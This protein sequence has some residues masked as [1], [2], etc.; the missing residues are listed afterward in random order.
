MSKKSPDVQDSEKKSPEPQPPKKKRYI[1]KKA[2]NVTGDL[3][4]GSI[5]AVLKVIGTI[6]LIFLVAGMMF[7]CVFAYYVKT[8]L[9]PSFDLSLEDLKLN[10]SSTLW[11]QDASGEWRE[12][13]TLSGSEKRVWV[14][15]ED[16]PWYLEKAL[17]AIEDKRFYEHKGVDWYRTAGAF[18]TM[19][20]KMDTSYGGSTITQQL[21]KNLTGKDDVTIQRKLSEI[22]GALELE[23]RYD[24]QEIVEW[25]LNA[26]CFGQGCY[27]VQ[28]AAQTYFGK[29]AKDLTLAESAAIVGI[30][31]LPTYY[32]PF[33]NEQNNK[34]R[35]E[36]ILREMYEQGYIDYQQYKDAVAEELVFT[37]SPGEEYSQ[38]IYS[39]YTEVV[40]DD[41]INDLMQLKGISRETA[42]TL[43]RNGG[44]NV[45][46]CLDVNVQNNI[47][48][49]YT[50]LE[51]IPNTWG[52]D[53]QLQSAIVV[54]DPYDG[55]ILGLSGGVGEKTINFGLNR[56]TGTKR[57]PGS[58]IK[59]LSAYGPAI[60]L[61]LITPE[62]TV[63]DSPNVV[64][65]GIDWLP[66]N[67]SRSYMGL[68]TIY[69]ALQYSINTVAAQIVD[70][71]PQGPQTSYDYLVN[72]LGFTSL[73][74]E[75]DIA[76]APMSLGQFYNGCT[77]R[78]M[79][80]AYCSIV[81]DGIFT[82]SRTYTMLTD[83][84]GSIVIDNTPRTI[85]AFEPN[86]A[87]TLTY[88]L[89][90][91]V[92]HGTGT[93]AALWSVPVAGKTGSSGQYMD[94]W[95]VG[96]TPYYVAAVWTGYDQQ[97][98]IQVSGN[99]AAQL[100]KKVMSPLHDG[101]AWKSFT[102]PYLSGENTG[103]FGYTDPEEDEYLDDFIT[104]DTDTGSTGGTIIGGDQF[105][106]NW[107]GGTT[108]DIWGGGTTGDIWG[109]DSSGNWGGSG[110]DDPFLSG[111]GDNM[112]I[113]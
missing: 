41:V 56:A 77:V 14:D 80:Q 15:Y 11:Y 60:D 51:A 10:E 107:T 3:I 47:D 79:A 82:Y 71:L 111:G 94:R 31:N 6:L 86:T 99:P 61:G 59:P 33:Y 70:I 17:V 22:F 38:T 43:L 1:V 40:I 20:A 4:S 25:Y 53:Q 103:I 100:W 42:D 46:T 74:P 45:Y 98:A 97:E 44:Y 32:D 72:H 113:W 88:L 95:F 9:V 27:G 112:F 18:V 7:T 26:V 52:S 87:Y 48:A 21:I 28:M 106:D 62:T 66:A 8:C 92:E 29:D 68:V 49:I 54:M 90:N 23:K 84:E 85:Q 105:S 24:K 63:M 104:T 30:T 55:R 108:G 89:Q 67:D 102:Y 35:Q 34:E 58:S 73:V 96:C 19:F 69:T 64:L 91:A 5:G 2:A 110:A 109:G 75:H 78:E 39:Y 65:N 50:D 101:L 36:T 93:E 76:Y 37:R 83:S 12:L 81:N 13:A 16:L 57:P